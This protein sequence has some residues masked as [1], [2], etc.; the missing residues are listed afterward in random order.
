[1]AICGQVSLLAN[2][3]LQSRERTDSLERADGPQVRIQTLLG[4]SGGLGNVGIFGLEKLCGEPRWYVAAS[5]GQIMRREVAKPALINDTV[6]MVLVRF[7]PGTPSENRTRFV[8]A[9]PITRLSCA[10]TGIRTTGYRT[11]YVTIYSS[12]STALTNP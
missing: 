3:Y 10:P 2:E 7:S 8:Y 9:A 11:L 4:G 5:E 6:H 1:M 12:G